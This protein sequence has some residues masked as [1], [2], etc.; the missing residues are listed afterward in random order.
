MRE[1]AAGADA[2][3]RSLPT[4]RKEAD[5]R[6]RLERTAAEVLVAGGRT[7]WPTLF[8]RPSAAL[9]PPEVG[10]LPAASRPWALSLPAGQQADDAYDAPYPK[11]CWMGL[12]CLLYLLQN[13]VVR[14]DSTTQRRTHI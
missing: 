3:V 12:K 8:P 13:W 2:R 7:D 9:R 6:E 10:C 11:R 5:G 4:M 1:C 14:V